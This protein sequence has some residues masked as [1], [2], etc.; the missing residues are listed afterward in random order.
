MDMEPLKNLG[1]KTILNLE[2]GVYDFVEGE[3]YTEDQRAGMAGIGIIHLKLSDFLPP[4][5][6]DVKDALAVLT[7]PL[8]TPVY[9]HCL[10]GV[11]R[12]GFVCAAYRVLVQNWPV[13]NAVAEMKS[14]GFHTPIPYFFWVWRFRYL[15]KTLKGTIPYAENSASS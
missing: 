9:V 14:L 2:T 13:E 15:M 4:S 12:T 6:A 10:H 3:L 8:K 11:D 5:A 7:S 1:I